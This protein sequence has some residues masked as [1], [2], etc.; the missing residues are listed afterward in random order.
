MS[1]PS[2]VV[3]AK[4]MSAYKIP[5]SANAVRSAKQT[6]ASRIIFRAVLHAPSVAWML[7]H[8]TVMRNLS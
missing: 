8:P 6:C 5:G 2:L 7:H 3:Q 4:C 1:T